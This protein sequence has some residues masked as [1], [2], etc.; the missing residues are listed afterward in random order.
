MQGWWEFNGFVSTTPV[1]YTTYTVEWDGC[2]YTLTPDHI[3]SPYPVE[4]TNT[5]SGG[6]VNY[7][8]GDTDSNESVQN[9][10]LTAS[11]S[12]TNIPFTLMNGVLEDQLQPGPSAA[13]L[14][15][16]ESLDPTGGQFG[17]FVFSV[18]FVSA[19]EL[20]YNCAA[21]SVHGAMGS[22]TGTYA[23]TAGSMKVTLSN[24]DTPAA[25]I[26]RTSLTEDDT[27]SGDA[28]DNYGFSEGFFSLYETRQAISGNPPATQ[29]GYQTGTYQIELDNLLAGINY[30]V[31]VQWEQRTAAGDGSGNT[32]LYG[33][34]W[35][36]ADTDVI[37]FV[38]SGSTQTTAAQALPM[39]TSY[40]KRIKS[41][42]ISAACGS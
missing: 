16:G 14:S 20:D 22:T 30:T 37:S 7:G 42:E 27:S 18:A 31:T 35:A 23:V 11:S 33:S 13:G 4:T 9:P 3:V 40:Q 19:T 8:S 25:A 29:F 15:T 17:S 5:W 39:T 2:V 6:V 41:I 26:A 32:S 12:P 38:A 1:F 21:Q 10:L 28:S 34:S 24:P 36:D